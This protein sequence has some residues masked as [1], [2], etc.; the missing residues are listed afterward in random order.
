[1]AEF[2]E[3]ELNIEVLL[4]KGKFPLHVLQAVQKGTILLLD[5]EYSEPVTIRVNGIPKFKGEVITQGNQFG[6]KILDEC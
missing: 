2:S 5:E 1:M 4:G 3:I 6:V